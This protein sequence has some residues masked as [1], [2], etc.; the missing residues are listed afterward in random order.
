MGVLGPL[1]VGTHAVEAY[2]TMSDLHCD[3]SGRDL[4]VNC[5][6]AGDTLAFFG[7][8]TVSPGN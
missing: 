4:E 5:L 2:W 8:A 7:E 1:S 3:G 6:A